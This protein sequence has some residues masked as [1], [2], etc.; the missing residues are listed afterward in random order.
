MSTL[1]TD[2]MVRRIGIVSVILPTLVAGCT[3]AGPR[4]RDPSPRPGTTSS[5]PVASSSAPV[6]DA[7]VPGT[8]FVRV[9]AKD[10]PACR[11]LA[12]VPGPVI[13]G[14]PSG[15]PIAKRS[16][17]IAHCRLGLW[18]DNVVTVVLYRSAAE[19]KAALEAAR[20]VG[21]PVLGVADEAYASD[22]S[23]VARS[24]NRVY[25]FVVRI[26]GRYVGA[27]TV[28]VAA[29]SFIASRDPRLEGYHRPPAGPIESCLGTVSRSAAGAILG[30]A[31]RVHVLDRPTPVCRYQGGLTAGSFIRVRTL[32]EERWEVAFAEARSEGRRVRVQGYPAFLI[33]DHVLV[34]RRSLAVFTSGRPAPGIAVRMAGGIFPYWA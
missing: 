30:G 13:V 15:R 20:S 7:D 10:S 3:D 12:G 24:G 29:W 28:R 5:A 27:E 14:I 34:L 32:P 1:G 25:G 17:V 8:A 6:V 16:S 11:I 33:G 2:S 21:R 26:H 23:V 9:K 19:A 18:P 31:V 4:S 22:R